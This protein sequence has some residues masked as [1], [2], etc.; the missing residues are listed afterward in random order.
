MRS[1]LLGKEAYRRTE[2][3]VLKGGNQE[4]AVVAIQKSD[5]Q[6]LFSD[7][8]HVEVLGLPENCIYVQDSSVDCANRSALAE[9]AFRNQVKKK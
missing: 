6:S 9:A 5:D 2:F 8:I 7:I 1:Y 3:I 4:N